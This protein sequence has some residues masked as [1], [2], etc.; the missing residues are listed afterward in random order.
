MSSTHKIFTGKPGTTGA[1]TPYPHTKAVRA[2]APKKPANKDTREGWLADLQ[3]GT[4]VTVKVAR[5]RHPG[6]VVH[7]TKTGMMDVVSGNGKNMHRFN[8]RGYSMSNTRPWFSDAT[9]EQYDPDHPDIQPPKKLTIS[10]AV[11]EMIEQA[12]KTPNREETK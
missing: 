10:D 11:N 2:E 8:A 4:M 12:Y 9:L 3:I 7:I 6:R 5:G 1:H